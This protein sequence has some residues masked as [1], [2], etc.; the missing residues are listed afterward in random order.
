MENGELE[1]QSRS[2]HDCIISIKFFN[3][4]S[5]CASCYIT[6]LDMTLYLNDFNVYVMCYDAIFD[7]VIAEFIH[8]MIKSSNPISNV[9]LNF[10]YA[11]S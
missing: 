4:H 7:H 8:P 10:E 11:L 1:M 3:F 5:K 6:L 2:W 9:L